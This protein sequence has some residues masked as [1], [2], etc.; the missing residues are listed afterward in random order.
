M[1]DQY[2]YTRA[3]LCRTVTVRGADPKNV[4]GSSSMDP[5]KRTST[6]YSKRFRGGSTALQAEPQELRVKGGGTTGKGFSLLFGDRKASRTPK[7]GQAKHRRTL[8]AGPVILGD[9]HVWKLPYSGILRPV[10][11]QALRLGTLTEPDAQ[12]LKSLR[13][14]RCLGYPFF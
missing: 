14:A 1:K 13:P 6:T 12:G 7:T 5:S 10:L 2:R 3:L 4:E 11:L 9:P 8:N